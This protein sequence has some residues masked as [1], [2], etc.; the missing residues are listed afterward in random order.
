M[1]KSVIRKFLSVDNETVEPVMQYQDD[2]VYSVDG[3]MT[4]ITNVKSNYARGFVINDD[5]TLSKTYLARIENCFAHGRT[6][7]E[8]FDSATSKYNINVPVEDRIRATVE[9]YPSLDTEVPNDK[10]FKLHNTLTGSCL[11]GREIFAKT[12]NLNKKTGSM[13]MRQFIELTKD[14][15]FGSDVIIKL[16]EAYEKMQNVPR[17]TI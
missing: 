12:H 8:A 1:D 6:L 10:L 5:M 15:S 13:T 3:I 11:Y 17:E 2:D 16:L 4:I 9:K 14:G 7:K